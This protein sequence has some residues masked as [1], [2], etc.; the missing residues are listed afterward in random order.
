MNEGEK[1][2]HVVVDEQSVKIRKRFEMYK[3]IVGELENSTLLHEFYYYG[4]HEGTD[5]MVK[6]QKAFQDNDE[7]AFNELDLLFKHIDDNIIKKDGNENP[8][9]F[10]FLTN[11]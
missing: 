7:A 9:C 10:Y 2:E 6:Y 11:R 8:Y 5:Y 1:T 3:G 4:R